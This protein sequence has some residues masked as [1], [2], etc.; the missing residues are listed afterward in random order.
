MAP[1][2][3]RVPTVMTLASVVPGTAPAQ[4]VGQECSGVGC[5]LEPILPL[6]AVIAIT[7]ML[8]VAVASARRLVAGSEPDALVDQIE[9]REWPVV[10]SRQDGRVIAANWAMRESAA[11]RRTVLEMLEPLLGTT[12]AEIYRLSRVAVHDGL[13]L[14]WFTARESGSS[15]MVAVQPA[16]RKRLIW[17]L[18]P[19]SRLGSIVPGRRRA[20]LRG[21]AV[22]LCAAQPGR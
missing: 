11:P 9:G 6:A 10:A 3:L 19:A 2:R 7:V 1:V 4:A 5:L 8:V 20:A 21:P 18:M 15:M 17:Q 22:R 14:E 12:A 16:S 13:A